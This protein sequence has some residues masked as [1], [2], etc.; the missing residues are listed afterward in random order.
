MSLPSSTRKMGYLAGILSI[1]LNLLLFTAKG[2]AAQKVGSVAIWADAWHTLSDSIT[3]LIVIAGFWISA[4][5]PDKTHPFGHGRAEAI[6][7]VII[8][9]LLCLVGIHF[10]RESVGR[11]QERRFLVYSPLVGVVFAGSVVCK[12]AMAQ[13]S[14]WAGKR[15]KAPSLRADAWHHRSDAIASGF[16]L[17][18]FLLGKDLWWLDGVMGLIVSGLLFF[19]A[20]D[21]LRAS[22]GMLLGEKPATELEDRVRECVSQAIPDSS[23]LHHVHLHRYGDHTE[24]TMHLRLPP[25]MRLDRAHEI[26]TEVE[27]RIRSE[28][29]ME[30]TIHLEP[31]S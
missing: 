18:G 12:E 27:K 26:A 15:M 22:S 2:F 30:S 7:T 24:M 3:S 23:G 11:L 31:S 9:V 16:I 6:A 20:W 1:V 10:L 19:T 21:V 14:L 5:P 4:R 8:A 28:M 29:G 25:K 17:V 13:F